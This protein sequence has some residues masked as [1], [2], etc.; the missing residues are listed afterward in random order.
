MTKEIKLNTFSEILVNGNY[1]FYLV[2]DSIN[3]V[4]IS[5]GENIIDDILIY[6]QNDS[7]IFKD[8]SKS[9]WRFNFEK[10]SIIL[11]VK[12]FKKIRFNTACNLQT[13]DT[14]KMDAIY[15]MVMDD[16]FEMDIT[17][18]TNK[19]KFAN[20]FTN[21]GNYLIKGK[22]NYALINNSAAGYVDAS[23]FE[24]ENLFVTQKSIYD[25]RVNVKNKLTYSILYSG[26]IFYTG[27]PAEIIELENTG[28]GQLI[29]TN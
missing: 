10:P 5:W 3:R 11:H 13:I 6:N 8:N 29:K 1:N 21:T 26:S 4:E 7:L 9:N 23:E 24:V 12:D 25:T 22:T 15:F 27:S 28:E 20:C 14:L 18:E 19:F 2:N 17:V 16:L